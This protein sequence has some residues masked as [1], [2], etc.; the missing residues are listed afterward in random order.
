VCL[1][2]T[3]VPPSTYCLTLGASFTNVPGGTATWSFTNANYA[4]E[5]GTVNI[6]ISKAG[7]VIV[8]TPYSVIY[9]AIAHTA[10]GTVKGVKTEDLAGLNLSGTNHTNA[11]DY[12]VDPW[13]FTDV[14]GNYSNTSGTVHNLINK[15]GSTTTVT[16]PVSVAYTGSSVEPCTASYSGIGGLSGSL[17]P[18]YLNN[19]DVGTATANANYAGGSNH[20]GSS[21]S[22]TFEIIDYIPPTGLWVNPI[23]KST[24]SGIVPL[25]VTADDLGSGVKEVE[26][27][28]RRVGDL[29]SF[30]LIDTVSGEPY[31]TNWATSTLDLDDYTLHAV[32]RDNANNSTEKDIEVGVSAIISAEDG[33]GNGLTTAIVTWIT[34]RPTKSR[35]VY[36]TVQHPTLDLTDPNYGYAFSTGTYD[37][38]K[39]LSHAVTL[40]GLSVGTMYFYRTISEGSPK[41]ISGEHY[42]I[43][44]TNAGP[45]DTSGGGG[46]VLGVSTAVPLTTWPKLAFAG[47]VAAE[48]SI[49][50]TETT[51]TISPEVLAASDQ[52][53]K[54][55]FIKWVLTHKK[56]S[57]GVVFA[58][59]VILYLLR[60]RKKS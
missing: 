58:L 19:V 44:N 53:E 1:I 25:E 34:D 23:D 54:V 3:V 4:N 59:I 35:V 52:P 28:Y 32:I 50:G 7:P 15:A 29:G 36:D 37:E 51:D 60:R 43:T 27:W 9:D 2:I 40:S 47:D 31:T 8:V 46:A 14:T 39:V 38:G 16:C 24:V 21:D 56:I 11:G 17:I 30:T 18:T 22:K 26:F 41:A 45:P 10:T 49:L 13:T 12:L 42:I 5:T 57:L 6:A 48:E 33:M 55:G 20:N